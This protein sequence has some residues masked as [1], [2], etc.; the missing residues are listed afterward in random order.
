MDYDF[1]FGIPRRRSAA[2]PSRLTMRLQPFARDRQLL[3][4]FGCRTAM[5][6]KAGRFRDEA[7]STSAGGS[8]QRDVRFCGFGCR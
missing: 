4:S 8:P 2:R 6:F 1:A 7:P 3:D 5:N